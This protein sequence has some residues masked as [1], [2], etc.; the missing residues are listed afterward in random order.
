V[1]KA[2]SLP[3]RGD[4][5]N[6][7]VRVGSALEANIRKGW[8]GLPGTKTLEYYQH[9]YITSVKVLLHLALGQCL[10]NYSRNLLTLQVLP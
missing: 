2:W 9:S 10:K 7:I 1:G 6:S 8:K 5:E 3:K 4:H